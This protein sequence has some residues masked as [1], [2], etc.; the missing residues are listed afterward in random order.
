[1]QMNVFAVSRV[2][3][4]RYEELRVGMGW[5]TWGGL[6]GSASRAAWTPRVIQK[7]GFL[8]FGFW[9]E[10]GGL[11]Y[12]CVS[13]CRFTAMRCS[14]FCFECVTEVPIVRCRS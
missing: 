5:D 4:V 2:L 12:Q 8:S 14:A 13:G 1:M 7:D 11:R 10:A 6:M 3:G 9:N